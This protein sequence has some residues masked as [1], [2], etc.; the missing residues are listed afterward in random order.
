MRTLVIF[1]SALLVAAG[2]GGALA[3][4]A[5]DDSDRAFPPEDMQHVMR[6]LGDQIGDTSGAQVRGLRPSTGS[7][8]YCGEVRARGA[9]AD[10]S[11][12]H[13]N[14]YTKTAW[15]LSRQAA[16]SAYEDVRMR[17]QAFGCLPR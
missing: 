3:Q 16:A 2:L 9:Y 11:P 1:A 4:T 15:I 6:I 10:W 17:V 12:F 5:I 13:A 14:I 7:H 8:G